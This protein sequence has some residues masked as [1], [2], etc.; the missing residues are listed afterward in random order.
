VRAA[1]FL[2]LAS[3]AFVASGCGSGPRDIAKKDAVL[4]AALGASDAFGI[5]AQPIS[6]GY[7]YRIRDTLDGSIDRVDLINLG[8]PGAEVDRIADSA[9]VFLRTGAKP[10]LV[11]MWTGANDVIAGRLVADFEPALGGILARLR[12]DSDAFVVIANLP[13]LTRLPRFVERP[14][15]AVTLERI[16]AFNAAITRQ[17][18]RYDVPVVDLFAQPVERELVSDIDGFHPSNEGH[19]RIARHFLDVILPAI[20]LQRARA[21]A[22]PASRRE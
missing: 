14:E 16:R 11:T 6:N 15:P 18:K 9:R 2:A 13:D 5:G 1:T 7:V 3:L 8:I 17:A 20:G 19:A 4:Y 21:A 10:D 12:D 22:A